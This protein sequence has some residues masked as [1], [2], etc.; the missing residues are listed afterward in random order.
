VKQAEP[1]CFSGQ[2]IAAARIHPVFRTFLPQ[3]NHMKKY[4]SKV[5]ILL[6]VACG[7]ANLSS[8]AQATLNADDVKVQL[9]KDWQRAKD[10]T[11]S[12]LT[13]MPADKYSYKVNDSIRTFAQQMLHLAQGNI[14]LSSSGTGLPKL[15]A[16]F[17]LEKSA[18]AQ[19]HDSVVYYVKESYDFVIDG[20]NKLDAAK[21]GEKIGSGSAAL[22]RLMWINKA[23][24]HQTHHRGQTTIYI[25]ALGIR[26]PNERLF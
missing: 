24:E 21:L 4:Y 13:T 18:G 12:Y 5:F 3:N 10:Y 9:I 2:Q 11:V 8:Y 25:R 22:T 19:T 1:T 7:F 6:F 20:I 15:Y 26:P 17:Q 14:N 23:F 16:N